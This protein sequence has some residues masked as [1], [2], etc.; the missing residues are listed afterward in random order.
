MDKSSLRKALLE[1][2]EIENF[3]TESAKKIIEKEFLPKIENTVKQ[4]LMEMEEREM[5][6]SS[7]VNLEPG[8]SLNLKVNG[9]GT[10]TLKTDSTSEVPTKTPVSEPEKSI[11]LDTTVEENP[12]ESNEENEE[13]ELF[14]IVEDLNEDEQD[15]EK[16][17]EVEDKINS[18]ESKIDKILALVGGEKPE[19]EVEIVDDEAETEEA[20][21][22]TPA[23]EETPAT[24]EKPAASAK[25]PA[26]P[27]APAAAE[28]E[29]EEE[30]VFEFEDLMDGEKNKDLQEIKKM[31]KELEELE[32]MESEEELEENSSEES[33]EESYSE[34]ELEEDMQMEAMLDEFLKEYGDEHEM[35]VA[36]ALKSS[37][38]E[39][40][41][42]IEIAESDEEEE[43]EESISTSL[44]NRQGQNKKPETPHKKVRSGLNESIKAQ[45]ESKLDELKKENEGLKSALKEYK[46]SFVVL[47]KQIN[48][49]QTFNAK[50]AYANKV[51]TKGGLTNEEKTRISEQFDSC[52]TAEEVKAVYNKLI[53]EGVSAVKS[54]VDKIKLPK[55]A[56]NSNKGTLYESEET[57]RMKK[58][59]GIL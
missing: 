44:T 2:K 9:D 31:L 35:T 6:D 47:R 40:L 33:E 18:L 36:D 34:E 43:M 10:I 38:E 37:D 17:K 59:A 50:L 19:G 56:N 32:N 21:T 54:S 51:F 14:E 22:E 42:E 26:A 4:T 5:E 46:D 15:V 20:P 41:M 29:E 30:L 13:E 53:K 3:A 8:S 57:K 12:E 24:E 48:E 16:I 11:D 39:E 27:E 23:A 58:L 52:K 45:Y 55:A 25:K 28:E 1:A 49:V 7:E